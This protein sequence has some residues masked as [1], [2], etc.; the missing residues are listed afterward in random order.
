MS[1]LH[2]PDDLILQV[3]APDIR[4]YVD[5]SVRALRAGALR[6]AVLSLWV[7][8][9]SDIIGKIR[10]LAASGDSQAS[11][12]IAQLETWIQANDLRSLQTFET[13][14]LKLARDTYEFLTPIEADE[15][16]RLR[17]DRHR[18]AH[19]ALTPDGSLYDPSPEQIRAHLVAATRA[20]FAHPPVQGRSALARLKAEVQGQ[21]FPAQ[22]DQVAAY[23]G[24]KYIDRGK[25]VLVRQIVNLYL[26]QALAPTPDVPRERAL[27]ILMAVKARRFD[28]YRAAMTEAWPRRVSNADDT[29]LPSALQLLDLDADLWNLLPEHEQLRLTTFLQQASAN[30]AESL[31]TALRIPTLHGTA[32]TSLAALPADELQPIM[33][34]HP[35]QDLALLAI[36]RLETVDTFK[37]G[38]HFLEVIVASREFLSENDLRRV[39]TAARTNDQIYDASHRTPFFLSILL[40]FTA[41]THPGLAP[42]WVAFIEEHPYFLFAGL[43]KTLKKLRWLPTEE[44][45]AVENQ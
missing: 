14:V 31:L 1:M 17:Q 18:C 35:Q 38:V 13:E 3:R 4:R 41:T 11:A 27:H 22:G 2:D 26:Q 32:R 28:V 37:A 29:V 40:H 20:L 39:L 7:A 36:E 34:A 6:A 12:E 44:P 24:P 8:V 15:L 33:L 42:D 5:E 23:L 21:A 30:Q 25:D 45:E 43:K 10:E 16:E 19:P 9:N